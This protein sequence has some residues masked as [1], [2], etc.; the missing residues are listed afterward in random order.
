MKTQYKI[1]QLEL[2]LQKSKEKPN[3]NVIIVINF[4]QIH[5]VEEDTKNKIIYNQMLVFIIYL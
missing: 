5:P 3:I 1:N 2:V 4:M